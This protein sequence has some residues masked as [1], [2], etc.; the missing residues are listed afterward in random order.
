M[1]QEFVQ[2]VEDAARSVMEEMHT[3]IPAKI[4]KFDASKNRANVKPYGTF[5]TGS[6]KRMT[7]P[8]ITGV[9]FIIPQCSS[10]NI[11]IA[12]P[13]KAGDDCLVLVS[14]VELDAWLGGGES[15][16]DMRFDLTSAVAIPGLK[17]SG[18]GILK[19]ACNEG[20]IILSNGATKLKVNKSDVEIQGN[21]KVTGDVM[22][23][24]ISLKKHTHEGVHGT[25]LQP[26]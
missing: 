11:H 7:Y 18:S 13:I 23:G 19:E 16:N 26:S 8:I 17:N 24:T 6:G 21:L 14:E 4:L 1:L 20:C 22:A 5:V 12:F 25:T 10:K 3:V 15:D 2:Q 9:P